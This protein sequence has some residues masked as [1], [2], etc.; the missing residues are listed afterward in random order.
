MGSLV[1]V[2]A[3]V[4]C[5]LHFF[6]K[7]DRWESTLKMIEALRPL[8]KKEVRILVKEYRMGRT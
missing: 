6:I 1:Y 4:D 5:C 2:G 3:D 8:E 7:K